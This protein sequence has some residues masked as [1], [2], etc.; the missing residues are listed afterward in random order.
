M[1]RKQVLKQLQVKRVF[2]QEQ[3]M[4]ANTNVFAKSAYE[5]IIEELEDLIISL[6]GTHEKVD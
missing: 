2:F 5:L 4:R 3:C 1:T 6:E